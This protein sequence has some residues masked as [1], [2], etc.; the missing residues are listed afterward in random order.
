TEYIIAAFDDGYLNDKS[1][2][3]TIGLEDSKEF[4][5]DL[6]LTPTD[7]PI[8]VENINY[9]FNSAELTPESIIAL[10]TLIDI[11]EVNPTIVIELMSHTDHIGSDQ[12]NFELSQRRA[13][14]V[15]DYLISKGINPQ[16]LVAKGYGE[17]WP[18]KVTRALA[19]KYS[20][21]KRGDEL[22]EEFINNLPEESQKE[23]AMAINRRTEFRVL[24]T[25]FHEQI[26]E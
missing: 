22:T 12:F 1:I 16:R 24:S 17:T 25:D 14:S 6:N 3:N 13:Q 11:L 9:A 18:K 20:F 15:V 19:R 23:A 7:A 26:Q 5:V 2:L 21:L 4:K 10:D 8:K